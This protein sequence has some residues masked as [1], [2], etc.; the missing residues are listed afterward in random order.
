MICMFDSRI[1]DLIAGL[2]VEIKYSSQLDVEGTY[3]ASLNW[4]IINSNLS[5]AKQ[6]EVLLHELGHAALQRGETELY[7][8]TYALHAKMEADANKFMLKEEVESYLAEH[9][10]DG[11]SAVKFLER[12]NLPLNYERIVLDVVA[13]M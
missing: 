12:Y 10:K 11:F 3:L 5:E 2:N 4:I 9:G 13:G 8:A 7:H 1:K 6:Y